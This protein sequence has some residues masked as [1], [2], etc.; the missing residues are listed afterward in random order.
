MYFTV[1]YFTGIYRKDDDD[2]LQY[3][4][5]YCTVLYCHVV[6]GLEVLCGSGGADAGVL[7]LR[8]RVTPYPEGVFSTWVMLAS[9]CRSAP[10]AAQPDAP[11]QHRNQA[12]PDERYPCSVSQSLG[13]LPAPDATFTPVQTRGGRVRGVGG[14]NMR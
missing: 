2:V 13:N 8:L 6:Q 1:T 10:P 11:Q 3:N 4:V 14:G 5:L 12:G 9:K 7:A